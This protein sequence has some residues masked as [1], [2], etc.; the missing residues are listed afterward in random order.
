MS[1]SSDREVSSAVTATK[2]KHVRVAIVGAG[3]S[4][5]G[6]AIR[7]KQQ[8]VNDF[9]LLE[10]ADDVGGTWR[11]NTYPGCACDV[12]AHLYSFSFAPNPNW[13]HTF[14]P[15]PE[16]LEYLRYC[17]RKFGVTPHICW[18]HEV[19]DAA[20]DEDSQQ[21]RITTNRGE[22]TAQLLALGNGPLSEPAIPPIPGIERFEG[23]MFHS[24]RWSHTYVLTG[25]RV[26]VIGTG[27]SAIQFVPH[28]Q[29]QVDR[30]L[31]FQRT[32]PW[33]LPR[34][35]RYIEEKR[36][37][38]FHRLPIVQRF[39]RTRM[40]WQRELLVLGFTSRT[41]LMD[42]AEQLARQH[43]EAQVP[44]PAL[45]EKLKPSYRMGCKRI[46]LSD[47]FYPAITQEN[48]EVITDR[49]SEVRPN[50][51]V[52]ADGVERACDTIIFATGFHVTDMPMAEHVY[53]R[54][55]QSLA[56]AW[57]AGPQAYL[58]TTVAGFPNLFLLIGPNTG[59][60]HTSMI[61]MIES[62]LPYIL[63]CLRLLERRR[64]QAFD[65]R[66]EAQ[67]AYN[68]EVQQRMQG[69][70]WTSGC[71][72]WYLDARGRNTTLWPGFTWDYRR[73]T[74]RFDAANYYLTS[75]K[76]PAPVQMG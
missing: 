3:F 22:F 73:K 57:S 20:W 43:M 75:R 39:I 65:V 36:R 68:A 34:L 74:R 23:T 26:A 24:S 21:W 6:L 11:D 60:G 66:P 2:P 14:A 4:G 7:L 8:G 17:A 18:N 56:D 32:P 27:A 10:R 63:G 41:R 44:D 15:Q 16:I 45:R 55:G 38:L 12:P 72:S 76:V 37:A 42:R 47:D 58:G 35:D 46:L 9:V 61:F 19:Q 54:G 71:A 40:Y 49:I 48:V 53:G 33:I 62:Q 50:S 1:V 70:V 28:I 64:L 51:I 30:L 13:S 31:L 52:T 29:P 67:D 25:K 5:L 59:L 69:T